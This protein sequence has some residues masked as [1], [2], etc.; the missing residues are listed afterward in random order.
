[1]LFIRH[2]VFKICPC[3]CNICGCKLNYS[4]GFYYHEHIIYIEDD[5]LYFLIWQ[6]SRAGTDAWSHSGKAQI[7]LVTPSLKDQL[8][9][10]NMF[11]ASLLTGYQKIL[12]VEQIPDLVL[13][14]AL[15]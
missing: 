7:L 14:E 4:V 11:S 2:S 5:A 9:E 10:C 3:S 1:M 13:K 12:Q 15:C 6:V 8:S